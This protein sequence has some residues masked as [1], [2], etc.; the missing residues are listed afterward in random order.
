[1]QRR[2]VPLQRYRRAQ[3]VESTAPVPSYCLEFPSSLY[4][5]VCICICVG[6]YIYIYMYIYIYIHTY[7]HC[8]HIY[9][10]IHMYIYIYIYTY[11]IFS[12]TKRLCEPASPEPRRSALQGLD[13][14]AGD[15]K[16]FVGGWLR[17]HTVGN[18][19]D[20][21]AAWG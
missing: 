20:P 9:V 10:Y 21:G 14:T 12:S 17:P 6:I 18:I 5:C 16:G 7:V 13:A 11:T 4:M 3:T 1:M 19:K 15:I 2:S 8:T